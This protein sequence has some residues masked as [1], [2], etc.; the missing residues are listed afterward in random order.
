MI[1]GPRTDGGGRRP[2]GTRDHLLR[3][4]VLA[5]YA[6]A[7][8]SERVSSASSPA[9]WRARWLPTA[10]AGIL[11]GVIVAGGVLIRVPIQARAVV[12]DVGAESVTAV[13]Q[14]SIP[15][16]GHTVT[17]TA[18]TGERSEEYAGVVEPLAEGVVSLHTTD[19][20]RIRPGTQ[21]ALDLGQESL[22]GALI[23][24]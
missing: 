1:D 12:T 16:A 13:V 6:V 17:F 20:A 9:T 10:L 22:L 5:A 18:D 24:S 3:P 21:L 14:G 7:P 4:D 19:A 15:S 23:G 8:R 11:T 2:D